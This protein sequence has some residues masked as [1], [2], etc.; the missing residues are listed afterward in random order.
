ML[1]SL[2]RYWD[3]D[4]TLDARGLSAVKELLRQTGPGEGALVRGLGNTLEDMISRRYAEQWIARKES[5]Q[6]TKRERLEARQ[7]WW[8]RG[9]AIVALI[10]SILPWL[11]PNK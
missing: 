2:N 3:W 7:H 9:I 8:T 6:Q 11:F 1:E 4:A 10:V 5:E